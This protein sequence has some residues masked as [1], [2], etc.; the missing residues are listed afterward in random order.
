[1]RKHYRSDAAGTIQLDV[2]PG[3]GTAVA[4]FIHVF[5][6]LPGAA[7]PKAP[8][9]GTRIVTET[10]PSAGKYTASFW[11][12]DYALNPPPPPVGP[13]G[14]PQDDSRRAFCALS[15]DVR[16]RTAH[17][18]VFHNQD[19]GSS[20]VYDLHGA[21]VVST[22]GARSQGAVQITFKAVDSAGETAHFGAHG[23]WLLWP[24]RFRPHPPA[25]LPGCPTPPGPPPALHP[26]GRACSGFA[27]AN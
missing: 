6:H 7:P 17:L 21:E 22:P 3:A 19:R 4:D 13:S 23:L 8:A 24:V 14:R 16:T 1:M 18:E 2:P 26:G 20:E 15:G 27:F 10:V 11:A 5:H 25:R 9:Y 12:I